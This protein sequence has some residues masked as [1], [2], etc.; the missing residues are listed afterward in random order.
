MP[1]TPRRCIF[2]AANNE[3]TDA[4]SG[5]SVFA[6]VKLYCHIV[7]IA[8]GGRH[9]PA[10]VIGVQ[11]VVGFFSAGRAEELLVKRLNI[12]I[13][14]GETHGICGIVVIQ[15]LCAYLCPL[16]VIVDGLTAATCAAAGKESVISLK[17]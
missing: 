6:F 16:F 7:I 14:V 8:Q 1:D 12:R 5:A 10:A 17:Y 2:F 3:K 9:F 13:L 11:Q 4:P 15:C